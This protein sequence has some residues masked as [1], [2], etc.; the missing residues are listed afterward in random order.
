MFQERSRWKILLEPQAQRDVKALLSESYS[1]ENMH[2]HIA[3]TIVSVSSS[4]CDGG[5]VTLVLACNNNMGSSETLKV[6]IIFGKSCEMRLEKDGIQLKIPQQIALALMGC[7]RVV[8]NVETTASISGTL[9]Y[10]EKVIMRINRCL[11]VDFWDGK[12]FNLVPDLR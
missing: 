2:G 10:P 12:E 11:V 8:N 6:Q 5:E 9:L 4:G 3:G 7:T 1:M